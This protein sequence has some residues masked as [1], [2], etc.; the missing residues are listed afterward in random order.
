[1]TDFAQVNNRDYILWT[2]WSL[3]WRADH[4]ED[5]TDS[6]CCYG[7]AFKGAIK[8]KSSI[9]TR[10]IVTTSIQEWN[11]WNS[12]TAKWSDVAETTRL[13]SAALTCKC[14][15]CIKTH[16]SKASISCIMQISS[17]SVR[18][19]ILSPPLERRALAAKEKLLNE[20][21]VIN[22]SLNTTIDHSSLQK[23]GARVTFW[24]WQD[25]L[26]RPWRSSAVCGDRCQP[27]KVLIWV[28][29]QTA[30]VCPSLR[31]WMNES[32]GGF[33]ELILHPQ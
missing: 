21:D 30:V 24:T 12:F 33:R 2:D 13:Q 17:C 14:G 23:A 27:D 19:S 9:C 15:H 10:Q 3:L 22:H 11:G 25:L 4:R 32:S 18:V 28:R 1:M 29:I 6:I 8:K 20:L 16:S 7:K 26:I 5:L 31:L